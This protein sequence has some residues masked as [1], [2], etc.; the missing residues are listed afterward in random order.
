MKTLL[1]KKF[2]KIRAIPRKGGILYQVDARRRGT[3]GKQEHYGTLTEA[4]RRATEIE[5]E[6]NANGSEG[7]ALS[8]DL[9]AMAL[10][11]EAM[12][13]PFGKTVAQA[14]EHY[15]DFLAAEQKRKESA[16]V[17]LLA[18][19]WYESKRDNKRKPVKPK[20]LNAIRQASEH[21]KTAWSARRILSITRADV[22]TYLDTLK[23]IR[24]QKNIRDLFSQ[25][26]NW[27]IEHEHA[28]KNPC[29]AI[30][31]EVPSLEEVHIFNSKQAAKVMELCETEH[32]DL[33]VY[34]AV[35]LFAGL[36]PG[37]AE[38]LRWE[39][40]HLEERQIVVLGS[41]SKPGETHTVHIEDNLY[42]WLTTYKGKGLIC[43]QG[44]TM[45]RRKQALHAALGYK[46][47]GANPKAEEIPQDIMRH[48]YASHYL[49]KYGN[50]AQLA[51]N[52]ANSVQVIRK[53]YKKIVSK[54]ET[55][56]YW[57]I[58]PA[59]IAE[60]AEA[61]AEEMFSKF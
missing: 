53:H 20:T 23:G 39:N 49:G 46:A 12:L 28:E 40:I 35:S 15:R 42:H 48:S 10:R 21:L 24:W 59:A 34:C 38:Q 11:G 17:G 16:L 54:S 4:E 1:R 36:R 29:A 18:T 45:A 6:F 55:V 26:F 14:C 31:V 8:Q 37:E 58:L 13:A 19:S 43:P 25:F 7:L 5:A 50:R 56:A 33:L 51:E 57:A 22:E 61:E 2:P 44:K 47:A 9:R 3:N 32:T 27:C 41:T 30:K 52:M 60:S